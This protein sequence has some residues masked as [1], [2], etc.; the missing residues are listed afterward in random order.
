MTNLWQITAIIKTEAEAP[1]RCRGQRILLSMFK[2][3]AHC[4]LQILHLW[5]KNTL[6]LELFESTKRQVSV[7]ILS[8]FNQGIHIE[9]VWT[10]GT[11]SYRAC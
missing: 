2:F 8:F 5:P 9:R 1:K 10:S 3:F 11:V 6:S 4:P 7:L